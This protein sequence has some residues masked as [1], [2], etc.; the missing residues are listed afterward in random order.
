MAVLRHSRILNIYAFCFITSVINM[1][2]T[3][4]RIQIIDNQLDRLLSKDVDAVQIN[5]TT[6]LCHLYYK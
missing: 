6:A 4:N 2:V 5:C 1:L 3:W